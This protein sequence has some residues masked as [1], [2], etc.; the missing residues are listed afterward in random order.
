MIL[1]YMFKKIGT[2]AQP[3]LVWSDE[4]NKAGSVYKPQIRRVLGYIN[5]E[6]AVLGLVN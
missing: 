1:N 4:S 3:V 6:A 2:T 5:L